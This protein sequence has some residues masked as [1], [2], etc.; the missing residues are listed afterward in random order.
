MN[1]KNILKELVTY[2]ECTRKVGHTT[3]VIEGLR[4]KPKPIVVTNSKEMSNHYRMLCPDELHTITLD[5][6]GSSL[7]GHNRPIVFD[8]AALHVIFSEALKTI[9]S[10][11]TKNTSNQEKDIFDSMDVLSGDIE[12]VVIK[13]IRYKK[14]TETKTTWKKLDTTSKSI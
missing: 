12:E 1:I 7:R 14:I 4:D 2:Y 8:N 13:G 9:E 6:I 10:I 11:E 5:Y 3:A